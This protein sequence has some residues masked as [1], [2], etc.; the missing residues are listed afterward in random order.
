MYLSTERGA[1]GRRAGAAS[2]ASPRPFG[3]RGLS[4]RLGRLGAPA[5]LRLLLPRKQQV[6]REETARFQPVAV[7]CQA[8]CVALAV[9][10]AALRRKHRQGATHRVNQPGLTPVRQTLKVT[11]P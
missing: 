8:V 2:P 9:Q 11:A 6:R 7:R 1:G 5:L 4:P 3:S 10:Q